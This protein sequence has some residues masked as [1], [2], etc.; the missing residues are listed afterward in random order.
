M[1]KNIKLKKDLFDVHLEGVLYKRKKGT[2]YK[3]NTNTNLYE[4]LVGV[5]SSHDNSNID[6]DD[7]D[8]NKS[9]FEYT[10][11]EPTYEFQKIGDN[12]V[13][14]QKGKIKVGCTEVTNEIVR[15]VTSKLID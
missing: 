5:D 1:K 4:L 6:Q 15:K 2:V 3:F 10:N 8:K 9:W 12:I 11:D 7:F 14:F 13:K